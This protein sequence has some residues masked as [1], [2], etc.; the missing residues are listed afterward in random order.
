M[1]PSLRILLTGIFCLTTLRTVLADEPSRPGPIVNQAADGVFELHLKP[2][3]GPGYIDETRTKEELIAAFRKLM[4]RYA[5]AEVPCVFLNVCYQRAACPSEVWDTYWDVEEPEKRTVK[6]ARKAWVAHS[7]GVDPFAV[8]VARCREK[9][10]SPWMSIRMNDTHYIKDPTRSSTFWQAHP[11][12]RRTPGGGYDFAQK[13]VQEHYLALVAELMDRY[14]CD[15][16][17]MDW[18]RFPNH[19][20]PGEEEAGQAHLNAFMR[21]AK[22]LVDKAA[23]RR[24]HPVK[25]AARIPAVPEAALAAGLDGITWAREG[26]ADILVLSA[27]WRPSDLDIPIERWR[28]QIGP[29]EHKYL[30]AAA[31]D[32]WIQSS[33]GGTLMRDDVQSQAG[34]TAAML[35]RGADLIYLFNHFSAD[36][37]R[38]T[39]TG[40]DGRTVTMPDESREILYTAG[41]M[42]V[43]TAHPRRHV[44]SVHDPAPPGYKPPLPAAIDAEHPAQFQIHTGPKPTGGHAVVRIGLADRPG[45]Q[46]AR[47]TVRFNGTPCQPIEDLL[48]PASIPKGAY[49]NG[50]VPH[51]AFVAPRVCRFEVPVD[52]V[53]RGANSIEIGLAEGGGQKVVWLE[54]FLDP[55]D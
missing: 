36:D 2:P 13:A 25:I 7:K 16:V 41:R 37:F 40:D 26:L 29:V 6:W 34:F 18:M 3:L 15:G 8:C 55:E 47:L 4:D 23:A 45:F 20:K 44:L 22:A 42:E 9:G 24:G 49:K 39:F 27:I 30:L 46:D 10:I 48:P 28:E 17:E 14:D 53:R 1:T 31:T 11:E 12:L 35:D 43:A 33:R 21:R 38:M 50:G 5:E 51:V 32:L 52:A 19:F 54:V